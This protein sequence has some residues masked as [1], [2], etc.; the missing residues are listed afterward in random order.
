[1]LD[2]ARATAHMKAMQT[3]GVPYS[4]KDIEAVAGKVDGKSEMDA[5]V[6][7]MQVLGTMARLDYGVVY[8][9]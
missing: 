7:Y 1:M 9:E 8:R 2:P 5:M 6:A 4:D 3:L